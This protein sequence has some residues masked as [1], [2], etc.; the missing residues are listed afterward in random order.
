MQTLLKNKWQENWV[1]VCLLLVAMGLVFSRAILSFASVLVMVPFFFSAA[2]KDINKQLLT[3]VLLILAPVL[4][5]GIWSDNTT[6]WWNSVSVRIPVIT[7]MMGCMVVSFPAARWMLIAGIYIAC[8]AIGCC[9]S[10]LQYIIDPAVIQESYLRAKVLPTLADHDYVRFSW[11]VVTAILI[12]IKC[13][14]LVATKTAKYLLAVLSLFFAVYLHILA[15]KTGLLCLYAVG[16]IYLVYHIFFRK[17]WKTGLLFILSIIVFVVFA[18][19]TFPTLRN[20]IQYIRYDFSFYS[21]GISSPGL[22]DAARW[23]SIRAGYGIMQDHPATGVGFG[24]LRK[25]VDTWHDQHH[26]QSLA[27][28]RFLPANEWMVY[29]AGS[30]WPG[31]VCF[32]AG[33]FLLLYITTSRNILSVMLSVIAFIPFV[34]DD[35]LE[36]QLGVVMLAFI[37]FFAQ[38]SPSLTATRV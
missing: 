38:R 24:D 21:K 34:T 31:M 26:P 7:M 19:Q 27:Y 2:R 32:T 8:I 16:L 37:A 1:T 36:G 12:S 11:M 22:N 14:T 25:S 17:K 9:W 10:L 35:T 15:A 6:G 4:I 33:L 3:A 18:Y 28:E 20:R 30:G 5:S 23:N 29:G 13:I